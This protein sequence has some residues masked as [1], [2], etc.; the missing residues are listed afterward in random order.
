M[1]A[2]TPSI[3]RDLTWLAVVLNPHTIMIRT[4]VTSYFIY[5]A[6]ITSSI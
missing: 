3:F 4:S 5:T 6:C 2:P 1:L